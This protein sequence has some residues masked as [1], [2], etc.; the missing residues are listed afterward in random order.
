M[1]LLKADTSTVAVNT[2]EKLIPV[3]LSIMGFII[4][5]YMVAKNVV[6]PARISVF[7]EVLFCLKSK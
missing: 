1:I 7:K 6:I 2:P 4:I 3:L 5:M